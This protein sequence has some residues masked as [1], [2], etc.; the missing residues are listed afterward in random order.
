MLISLRHYISGK[1]NRQYKQSDI[2]SPHSKTVL[3]EQLKKIIEL[4]RH[5]IFCRVHVCNKFMKIYH[6]FKFEMK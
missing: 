4:N 5:M 3:I 1:T 2:K 6:Q